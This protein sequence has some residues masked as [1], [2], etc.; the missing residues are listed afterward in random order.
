[1]PAPACHHAHPETPTLETQ[2]VEGRPGRVLLAPSPC[3]PGGGGQPADR[4]DR[5][6][7]G[8]PL[9]QR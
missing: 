3:H 2:A 5:Q 1:M 6:G 7:Q 4:G 8:Q 9:A